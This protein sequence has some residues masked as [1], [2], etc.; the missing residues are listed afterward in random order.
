VMVS[1]LAAL[2]ARVRARG[3]MVV[4]CLDAF[5]GEVYAG[6]YRAGDPPV[7]IA[8]ELAAAPERVAAL[9]AALQHQDG[10]LQHGTLHLVGDGPAKWP[11]LRLEGARFD[12]QPPDAVEVGR[13]AAH[14]VRRGEH[15]DLAS[16]APRYIRPS[17]AELHARKEER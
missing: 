10:A 7:A 16:A 15:D 11:A 5:K 8:D 2:A 13:L 9:I 12:E 14:R 6:L 3:E 4:A 1:S 17:E